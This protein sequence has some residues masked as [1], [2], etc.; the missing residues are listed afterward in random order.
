MRACVWG[1]ALSLTLSGAP[2]WDVIFDFKTKRDFKLRLVMAEWT[3]EVN[4]VWLLCSFLLCS[5][6]LLSCFVVFVVVVEHYSFLIIIIIIIIIVVVVKS[7][8]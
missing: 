5:F 2:F 1:L 7:W 4:R 6:V 3:C 8:W